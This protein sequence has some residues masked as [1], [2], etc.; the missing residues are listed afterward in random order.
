MSRN[1]KYI[2]VIG[3]TPGKF[4]ENVEDQL[5]KGFQV[6]GGVSQGQNGILMQAVVK[7]KSTPLPDPKKV[8]AAPPKLV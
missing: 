7:Y 1:A 8:F 5:Q 2:V 3:K 4:A 6:V